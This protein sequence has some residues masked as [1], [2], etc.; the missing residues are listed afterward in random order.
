[1][2][3]ILHV[4]AIV[5]AAGLPISFAAGVAGVALPAVLSLGSLVIGFTVAIAAQLVLDDYATVAQ[6]GVPCAVEAEK[7]PL[8]LAA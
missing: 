7:S 5:C 3:N 2:K 6:A 8:R 4:F 1:M